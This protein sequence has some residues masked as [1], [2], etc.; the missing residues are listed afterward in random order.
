MLADALEAIEAELLAHNMVLTTDL[1]LPYD[2][3]A[4]E[5]AG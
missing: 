4:Q 5:R 2:I 3:S 1:D